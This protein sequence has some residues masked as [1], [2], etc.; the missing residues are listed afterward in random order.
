M[1]ITFE[2]VFSHLFKTQDRYVLRFNFQQIENIVIISK[3][4]SKNLRSRS[5]DSSARSNV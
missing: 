5:A 3:I 2:A 1:E 4:E